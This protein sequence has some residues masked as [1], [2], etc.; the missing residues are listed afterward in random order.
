MK[1]AIYK[2]GGSTRVWNTSAH[3]KVIDA[4]ELNHYLSEG[5][6]DHPDK[7]KAQPAAEQEPETDGSDMTGPEEEPDMKQE[8]D[9]SGQSSPD[10]KPVAKK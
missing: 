2:T 9:V 4:E 1:M 5:W 10:K 8:S 6:V 3:V 7:L